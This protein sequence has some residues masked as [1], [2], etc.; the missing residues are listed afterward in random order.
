MR[1]RLLLSLASFSVLF[2]LACSQDESLGDRSGAPNGHPNTSA[3]DAG[4]L[5]ASDLF[6]NNQGFE[7]G[8]LV[9]PD[10]RIAE[11]VCGDGEILGDEVCDDGN[12]M[13]GD[14]CDD[15]CQV[16]PGWACLAAAMPCIAAECGD[17]IVAGDEQCEDDDS[18][19]EDDDGCSA[20]C[21]FEPGYDCPEPGEACHLTVCNDGVKERGEPC[22]DG[23]QVVGDGCTPFCEVE[24][25]CS[26]GACRSR[27]GDGLILESDDEECDD[28]NTQDGDGCSASCKS[29]A[30]YTCTLETGELP[31]VLQ[32]PVTYRDFIALPELGSIR[33]PDFEVFAGSNVT[34]LLVQDM[35]DAEGKPAYAGICDTAAPIGAACPYGQQLTTADNFAQWYR[36][37]PAVNVTKVTRLPLMRD[38]A[39]GAYRIAQAAFYP[40]DGDAQS[41]VGQGKERGANPDHD[42]GFTSEIRHYFTYVP[43]DTAPQTLTFSGDDDV[44]VFI[45]HR[46]AV[47]IG[48]LHSEQNRSVQLDA[49]TAQMLGLEDGGIY[50]IALFHAERHTAQSNFNLT[51]SGFV[52]VESRCEPRC[53]DGVVA[54]QEECDDGMNTGGYGGCLPGCALGPRCGD[55]VVQRSA[56]EEC[57]DGNHRD[58]DTCSADCKDDGPG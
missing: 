56:G 51:L 22:D 3:R 17:G 21:R 33:H 15:E 14:G 19:P 35:L 1:L 25:D 6:G 7:A 9:L 49:A 39:D 42:Y 34:P 32:V 54:G 50:E 58:G 29:E 53:G 31:E 12:R 26:A 8:Q 44:W 24:P 57:D 36:D 4:D 43:S 47:D 23:N 48:G 38:P 52:S 5:D 37:V 30:G 55:R 18:P 13:V 2:L 16:E 27:C 28:G 40:W 11:N 46:L 41:W 10:A 45:N 20:S